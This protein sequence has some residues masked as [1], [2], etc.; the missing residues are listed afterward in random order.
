MNHFAKCIAGRD[1]AVSFPDGTVRRSYAYGSDLPSTDACRDFEESLNPFRS[2][3]DSVLG[4]FA[5]RLSSELG[6]SLMQ[7]LLSGEHDEEWNNVDEVVSSGETLD[8]FHSYQKLNVE[9]GKTIEFHVDQGL[10]LAF[11]PGLMM[12]T[13]G[14]TG[15]SEGF[16]VREVNGEDYEL[17][18]DG[19]DD[20]VIMLGDGVNQ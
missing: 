20:L 14:V 10:M 3:V 12:D 15:V 4:M 6:S 19:S 18:F 8:H 13:S 11:T 1:A 9:E 5:S 2:V 17:V 16:Y 7:P